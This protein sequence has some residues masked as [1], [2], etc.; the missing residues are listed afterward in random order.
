MPEGRVRALLSGLWKS[1]FQSQED[2]VHHIVESA[3]NVIIHDTDNLVALLLQIG[4]SPLIIGNL[5]V[6]RM[7]CAIDLDNEA[8]IAT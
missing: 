2:H 8:G 5:V 7:R 1:A 4:S 6:F 3:I